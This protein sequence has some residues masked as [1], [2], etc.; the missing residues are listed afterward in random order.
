MR[1]RVIGLELVNRYFVA[2]K[3]RLD[4]VT[5]VTKVL[6]AEMRKVAHVHTGYLKSTIYY[7]G[8]VAGAKAPYAGYEELRGGSHALATIA[9]QSFNTGK[10]LDEV[11]DDN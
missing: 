5:L 11:T 10:Y 9:I 1:V 2:V 8:N 3:E 4:D 7:K 6:A